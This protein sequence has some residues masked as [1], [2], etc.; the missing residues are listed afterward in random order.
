MALMSRTDRDEFR[1]NIGLVEEAVRAGVD[2]AYARKKNTHWEVWLEYCSTVKIDPHLEGIEDPI[3]YLQVFGHRYQ[4]GRIAPR[5]NSVK[6]KTV[7]DALRS[8]GQRL[9]SV[10]APDPRLNTFGKEDFQLA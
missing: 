6:F 5:G 7:S 4:I 8:V 3:P 10:G 2:P 9:A 1:S